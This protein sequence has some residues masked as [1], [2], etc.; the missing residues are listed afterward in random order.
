MPV[1]IRGAKHSGVSPEWRNI[2]YDYDYPEEL[3]LR[4]KDDL[5]ASI[6]DKVMEKA[7]QAHGVISNRFSSWNEMDKYLT[8][9]IPA[10]EEEKKVQKKDPRRPISVVF[11][12]TY[13]VRETLM[14]YLAQAFIQETIFM[15]KGCKPEDTKGAILLEQVIR[16]HCLK[17]KVGL[18][19]LTMFKDDLSYG[20][21]PVAPGWETRRGVRRVQRETGMFGGA[22]D[23]MLGREP[24]IEE[25][26][27]ILFEGNSLH[28]ID[29]YNVLPDPNVSIHELQKGEFFG[30]VEES[31]LMELL[32]RERDDPDYFNCLYLKHVLGRKISLTENQHERAART[33]ISDRALEGETNEIEV[34]HMYLNLIPKEWELGDD[35]YPEKWLFSVAAGEVVIRAKPL[36]LNHG[37][38]PVACSSSNFDGYSIAPLSKLETLG[39][40]QHVLDFLFNSHIANVRKALNDMFVVDPYMINYNDLKDPEPGKLIRL[41]RPAWGKGVRDAVMQLNVTDVTQQ[42]IGD[43]NFVLSWM[44]NI[45]GADESMMGA[46]RKGGPERLTGMEFEGTRSSA[47]GR[48]GYIAQIIGL[49]AMQDIGYFFASHTQQLMTQ[50]AYV[51][52]IGRWQEQLDREYGEGAQLKATPFDL[53]IDYDVEIRDGSIPGSNFSQ[54]WVQMFETIANHPELYQSFDITRIFKHIA[55][56]SGA[57][58]VSEFLR[59]GG[60]MQPQQMGDE[61]A[62][63]EAERGNLVPVEGR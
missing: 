22:F 32:G 36:E 34:V 15:Y 60:Q 19:L 17:N 16:K 11:P 37:M 5:H 35:E 50:E 24:V 41:R 52:T 4:P 31:N 40:L 54:V 9:Y 58:N 8:A 28:N 10:D 38:Y 12:Y 49:Q 55:R 47:M 29:P 46:M 18:S 30:W 57:K 44:N 7:V 51:D 59:Q 6:R 27:T 25:E 61:E 43:A 13:V 3:K 45:S 39:G 53:L 42:N 14:A 26:E 33:R 48:L 23:R 20:I 1:V 62:V 63:R 2:H 56:N 21:G